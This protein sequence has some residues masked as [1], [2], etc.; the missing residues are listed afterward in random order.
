MTETWVPFLAILAF[1]GV[2]FLG[3]RAAERAGHRRFNSPRPHSDGSTVFLGHKTSTTGEAPEQPLVLLLRGAGTPNPGASSGAAGR[4]GSRDT[5]FH[6]LLA[7]VVESAGVSADRPDLFQM[8]FADQRMHRLLANSSVV[9]GQLTRD[10]PLAYYWVGVAATLGKRVL[11]VTDSLQSIQGVPKPDGVI[12]V[13]E[14]VSAGSSRWDAARQDLAS[15]LSEAL[16]TTT[17]PSPTVGDVLAHKRASES[18]RSYGVAERR[19]ADEGL[20]GLERARDEGLQELERAR[21][22]A[23]QELERW[24]A[25]R[26]SESPRDAVTDVVAALPL[27]DLDLAVRE[28]NV[29]KRA[30]VST[31]GELMMMSEEDLRSLRHLTPNAVEHIATV[32]EGLRASGARSEH[33]DS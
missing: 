19:A 31:A 13:P 12:L 10:E 9:I 25:S 16:E 4:T 26:R 14:D 2:T 17:R 28:Y 20:Q 29:L 33:S 11:V 3:S 6:E 24:R 8:D 1:A 30:G 15:A 23:L 21:D 5:I 18:A 22:E 7:P 32:I 27:E